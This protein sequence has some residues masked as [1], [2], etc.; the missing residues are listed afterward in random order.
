MAASVS[1]ASCVTMPAS[2]SVNVMILNQ[3]VLDFK[4]LS[5]FG[6]DSLVG[7]CFDH[8]KKSLNDVISRAGTESRTTI[9][10]AAARL[11]QLLDAARMTYEQE[12]NKTMAEVDVQIRNACN[13]WLAMTNDIVSGSEK[14]A[15]EILRDLENVTA[16]IPGSKSYLPRV[17]SIS[18]RAVVRKR[19]ADG[20]KILFR[21][22]GRF[23][24]ASAPRCKPTLVFNNITY[25]CQVTSNRELSFELPVEIFEPKEHLSY[26]APTLIA[27]YEYTTWLGWK[28]VRVE[29]KYDLM[30]IVLPNSPGTIRTTVV[31]S[32]HSED[33]HINRSHRQTI[34][35]AR[36][37]HQD[38]GTAYPTPG[39]L[40]KMDEPRGMSWFQR[41]G[42]ANM[43][44]TS[45]APDCIKYEYSQEHG[46][47]VFGV[48]FTEHKVI[49]QTTTV[50]EKQ[51]EWDANMV[52]PLQ[53]CEH[54]TCID[55]APFNT[56]AYDSY[57]PKTCTQ[58]LF[59]MVYEMDGSVSIKTNNGNDILSN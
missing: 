7:S 18:P 1:D 51:L 37:F 5:S 31:K 13:E 9:D 2:S 4:S 15:R 42:A 43:S 46:N 53:S 45:A 6:L 21:V 34:P 28:T 19:Y 12:L 32:E 38:F 39:Y 52:F 33:V 35:A 49:Q 41:N 17:D 22:E 23:E 59:S 40:I 10:Q 14:A 8:M 3:S 25:D 16:L 36:H 27:P 30:I 20:S 50:I 26:I 44:I 55:F 11:I 56:K 54:I 58:R 29:H 47:G 48:Y 57:V 24:N